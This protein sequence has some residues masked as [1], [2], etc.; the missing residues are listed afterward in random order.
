MPRVLNATLGILLLS[1][2]GPV[3]AR[4][5]GR[6]VWVSAVLVVFCVPVGLLAVACL[7]SAIRPGTLG[8]LRR[9]R[10]GRIRGGNQG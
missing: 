6:P 7:V 10:R 4:L 1:L 8:G 5:G 3:L 2:V 9:G